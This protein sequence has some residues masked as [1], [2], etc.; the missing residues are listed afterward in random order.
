MD[1]KI[2][3]LVE[4]RDD[5]HLCSDPNKV[6]GLICKFLTEF[7]LYIT[8]PGLFQYIIENL[9]DIDSSKM[10]VVEVHDDDR[11]KEVVRITRY[12]IL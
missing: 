1:I 7:G 10:S 2:A 4:I 12:Q 11:E 9:A 6:D 3:W 5:K 8:D